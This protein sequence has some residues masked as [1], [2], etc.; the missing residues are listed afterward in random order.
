MRRVALPP[1]SPRGGFLTQASV[2]KL[3][4]NGTTTSPVVRGKWIVERILGLPLPPP[5]AA[6]P[7]VEPDLRGAVTIRQQLDKHRADESCALCHRKIDPAGFALESFDV[8]GGWRDRYRSERGTELPDTFGRF[9]KNGSPLAYRLTL[10]VE[11]GGQ[12][13]DRRA[14]ADV[15]ELKSLLLSDEAQLARNLVRQ[16]LVYGTGAAERFGDRAAVEQIVQRAKATDYGVRSL[17][18]ALIQSE[19]FLN[20]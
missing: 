1:A 19:L 10:P 15:R 5:P 4:T 14:F 17:V 12:L 3:T 16:L 2:L 18:H 13:S 7:A 11:T 8:L 20:K 6:V 9:G